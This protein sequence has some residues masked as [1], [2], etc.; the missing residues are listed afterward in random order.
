MKF[1]AVT[2]SV[3]TIFLSSYPCCQD[4]DS[5]SELQ[6]F[7]DSCEGS[8]QQEVPHGND[9]PCSPFYNCGRCPGFTITNETL[10]FV[11]LEL[12]PKTLHIPYVEFLPKEVYF[13]ALKPP[14]PFEV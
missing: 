4:E 1:L 13:L 5:C 6:T 9:A 11:S 2:L 3:L 7:V 10:D 8:S 12:K 14:R